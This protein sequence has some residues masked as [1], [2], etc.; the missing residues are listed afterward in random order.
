MLHAKWGASSVLGLQCPRRWDMHA[1]ED[2]WWGEDDGAPESEPGA[3]VCQSAAAC[4]SCV[5]AS[6]Q[7]PLTEPHAP[8]CCAGLYGAGSDTFFGDFSHFIQVGTVCLLLLRHTGPAPHACM[9][10]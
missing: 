4:Q 5:R 6:Q 8:P 9:W 3:G 10:G 1:M 7:L 2:C